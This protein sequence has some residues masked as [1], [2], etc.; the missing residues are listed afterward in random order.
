VS[1]TKPSGQSHAP[2]RNT[3]GA[4]PVR[5]LI[6]MALLF[7]F[8]IVGGFGVTLNDTRAILVGGLGFAVVLV[9]AYLTPPARRRGGRRS[10]STERA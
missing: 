6:A 7:V 10:R 1:A 5:V 4:I 2:A 9:V 8:A 3:V